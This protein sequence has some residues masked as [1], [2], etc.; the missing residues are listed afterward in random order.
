MY[1]SSSLHSEFVTSPTIQTSATLTRGGVTGT[2]APASRFI[3]ILSQ[4]TVSL[5]NDVTHPIMQVISPIAH[6]APL[7]V[8]RIP[9][10]NRT[11]S[12]WCYTSTSINASSICTRPT[13]RIPVSTRAT[14]SEIERNPLH[15]G[16][17]SLIAYHALFQHTDDLCIQRAAQ[18]VVFDAIPLSPSPPTTF[19]L[20]QYDEIQPP[21]E[22][23]GIP[24]SHTALPPLQVSSYAGIPSMHV[25]ECAAFTLAFLNANIF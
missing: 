11:G 22:H 15:S 12:V 4:S 6:F 25:N 17:D 5:D 9:E 8:P 23:I 2:R 3:P 10:R 16:G 13:R 7:Y 21:R 1:A 18:L 24:G 20:T 14:P 19:M